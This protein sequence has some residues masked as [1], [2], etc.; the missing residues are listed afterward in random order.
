[1]ALRVNKGG[2][3]RRATHHRRLT[4]DQVSFMAVF[5]VLPLAVF[6]VFVLSPF[7][8]ALYYSTTNW[9]G[10]SST[11]SFIGV[12]NFSNL[13]QDDTFL[14]ALR[15]NV[16]LAIFVPAITLLAAFVIACIVTVGG[17]STGQV[18]GLKGSGFYR[19]ISFFPYAVPAII[20][21]LIWSQVYDPTRG[22]LNGVLT[23]LG[24]HHF[25][26]FAWLGLTST[27]MPASMFVIIWGLIGF[28]TVLFVAAIKGIPAETY[29]A[30]RIDGAGR[31]RLALSITLPQILNNVRTSYI[32]IGIMALDAFTY[33]Q[34]LNPTGG[35][36]YSTLTMTQS[37]FSTAFTKGKFGY[38]T[39]MGVVLA[40]VTLLFIGLVF[41]VFRLVGGRPEREVRS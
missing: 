29:E 20:I 25:Q 12:E 9:T 27:A 35:P 1:M 7:V 18:R 22:L 15:N 38:A 8:Q 11:M 30:A 33:M 39:A 13:F 4:F 37:I 17:P 41:V 10:F 16:L 28:Y 36:E 32:Y 21:G 26:G 31:V 23:D 24:L 2:P 3:S 34:A 5:L 19:V 6:V 40:V 14:K